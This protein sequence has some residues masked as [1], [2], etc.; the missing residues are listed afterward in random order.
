MNAI[1]TLYDYISVLWTKVVKTPFP[2]IP[3][4]ARGDGT[5]Y[6]EWRRGRYWLIC[7]ERGEEYWRRE[8][9]DMD[10]AAFQLMSIVS[11][12]LVRD[13]ELEF[14]QK[15]AG[16]SGDPERYSRWNWMYQEIELMTD[17]KESYGARTRAH[18]EEVLQRSPLS[19][20]E[21]DAARYPLPSSRSDAS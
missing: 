5:V 12:A 9:N 11:S 10:D 3:R 8:A 17:I 6:V 21:I 1:D 4:R 16:R 14:R 20:D 19:Q 7:E 13:R 2:P 15:Q 18:Y